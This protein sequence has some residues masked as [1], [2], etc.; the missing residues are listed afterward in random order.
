MGKKLAQDHL[1]IY[2]IPDLYCD[3]R[4]SRRITTHK[5]FISLCLN[6]LHRIYLTFIQS[7][8]QRST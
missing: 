5:Q 1:K 7:Y 3:I 6:N 8:T 2:L 4:K